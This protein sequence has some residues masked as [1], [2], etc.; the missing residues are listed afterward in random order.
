MGK[1]QFVHLVGVYAMVVVFGGAMRWGRSAIACFRRKGNMFN[2]EN[3]R[4]ASVELL[5]PAGNF[6][7]LRAAVRAGADAVYLGLDEF[8]ARRRADNFTLDNLPEACDYAHLRGVRVY[9][10]LNI[11]VFPSEFDRAIEFARKAYEAGAD[12]FIV[13]DIGLAAQLTRMLPQVPVHASTQM[14]T[15][16]AAGVEA[17]ARLGCS[18]VTLARELSVEEIAQL[19]DVAHTFGMDVEVFAHGALCVCYSGQCLMSSMIGGRS[20]NRGL[21][22]QACR[23]PYDLFAEG[24]DDPLPADGEHLLSPRDLCTVDMLGALVNAG[25]SSLKIEGRMKAADYVYNVVSVYRQ[26]LDKVLE[27]RV[28]EGSAQQPQ[29]VVATEAQKNSLS[30]AFSRGF[31][32]AYL[33]QHRGNDIMSYGR[34]NNRG[35]FVGRVAQARNGEVAID[36]ERPLHEGDIIQFWT[37]RGHF[38]HTLSEM[39]TDGKG[40]VHFALDERVGKGDRVFRVRNAAEAFQDDPFL[41]RIPIEGSVELHVGA[42]AR[43]RFA[44]LD[45]IGAGIVGEAWGD[46]VEPARTKALTR[47]DVS[48]HIDR[49]GQTSYVLENLSIDMDDDIGMGFSTLHHLRAQALQN[50]SEAVL[51]VYRQR[52]AK[53][54]ATRFAPSRALR[55]RPEACAVVAWASN[56]ACARAARRA[57]ADAVYVP[58]LNYRRG[59]AVLEGALQDEA[60][61]AGYP[62]QCVMALPTVDHDPVAGTREEALE[63]DPWKYVRAEKPV[64]A[65]SAA[66]LVRAQAEGALPEVGSHVPLTNAASLEVAQNWGAQRVWLSPELTLGQIA[67]LAE[68]SSVDLGITVIGRQEL[69]VTEHCALMS[70]GPCT[71]QCATCERRKQAHYL[72]DRKDFDFPVVT[73]VLGRSHIYNGISLD[74][75]SAL[76]DLID[77]G[78]DAVMVDTTLMSARETERM[79]GRVVGAR[80]LALAGKGSVSKS[81]GTTT[82]HLFKGVS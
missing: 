44:R 45:G 21:C 5:A 28:A 74:V 15:H 23:L 8:N 55:A 38:A 39:R 43:V 34:P 59:Q 6:E 9:V 17:A 77:I 71:Q 57:G 48:A 37:N 27:I 72:K 54:K 2:Q 40:L 32:T 19:A 41:P 30:E 47:R 68:T 65:D 7:C 69:M 31:T 53:P 20:A 81:R 51:A 70:Q 58:V 61:Q 16:N 52:D 63:F 56:P 1:L 10:T 46:E 33:T 76:S 3:G 42:P 36:A 25:V 24:S 79:V 64:Y 26:V 4:D 49:L 75:A 50:L 13:Q 67:E 66:S 11:V 62:K 29:A 82:G 35:V 78:I 12:A 80:N 14:N 18:R 60:D 73:D 22:A